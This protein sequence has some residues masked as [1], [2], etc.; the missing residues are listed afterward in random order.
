MFGKSDNK[1]SISLD[2]YYHRQTAI[3]AAQD[4][5]AL[6]CGVN[7]LN[8]LPYLCKDGRCWG[9]AAGRPL[10]SD[11]NHLS[12]FGSTLLLPMFQRAFKQAEHTEATSALQR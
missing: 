6:R 5:A 8:P 11:S 12:A 4:E 2:E 7:I 1:V 10:Y 9:D 3:W